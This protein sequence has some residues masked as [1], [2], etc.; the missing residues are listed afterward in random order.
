MSASGSGSEESSPSGAKRVIL[1]FFFLEF[2]M[3]G[4]SHVLARKYRPQIFADLIG[5]EALV[6]TV[7]NAIALNR[8]PQAYMLTGIR[9]VGKTTSARII[10]KGLNCIGEDGTGGMTPNPCGKCRHCVDI[11]AD[12]HIDVIEVDAAS[13]TGVDNVREIIESAKYNPVSARFKVYIIDEVHMMSKQAFNALL[14]TLEEPPERIKFIFATTEIR[15]VPITIL[16]RC[17]RFDLQRV[18]EAVLTEHL[19]KIC[20]QENVTAETEALRLLARAGEGSVRDSLSLLDQAMT[21]F[22]GAITGLAVRQMLGVSDKTALFDLFEALMGGNMATVFQLLEKLHEAGA[23]PLMVAQDLLSMT[24]HLTRFKLVPD[25]LQDISLSDVERQR[26]SALATRLSMASLTAAWQMLLKGIGEIK[27]TDY[28]AMALEMLLIRLAYLSEMPSPVQLADG[29][30]KNT[31]IPSAR[32]VAPMVTPD[33]VSEGEAAP[34]VASVE[35]APLSEKQAPTAQ[36]TPVQPQPSAF[37]AAPEAA[38]VLAGSVSPTPAVVFSSVEEIT[39]LARQRQE[40]ILA[41]NVENHMRVVSIESGLIRS[42]FSEDAPATL[43]ADLIRFLNRETGLSW[44]IET[45][46][47]ADVK[48]AREAKEERK[49]QLYDELSQTDIVKSVMAAFPHAKIERI[50]EQE[51]EKTDEPD[52]G[53]SAVDL[54]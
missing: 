24:H 40:R 38:A 31:L 27:N 41:F 10:A 21:Q 16:S 17:Q 11:A 13:N 39:R 19:Q 18:D 53:E 34:A 43:G 20:V 25:L 36:K 9:G 49:R 54:G 51:E 3:A 30:K 52:A 12:S 15:K 35:A 22:E 2:F 28:P 8:L 33:V 1:S 42:S 5:Q 26:S 44:K 47:H 32:C 6:R 46:A 45:L 50:R 14:K 48:T 7:T 23:D 29:I 37:E 4:S